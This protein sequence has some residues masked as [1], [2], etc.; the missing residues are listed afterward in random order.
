MTRE[1]RIREAVTVF[2]ATSE[3]GGE[4]AHTRRM[5]A[6]QTLENLGFS[7]D[8]ILSARAHAL[9]GYSVEQ[10]LEVLAGEGS[11]VVVA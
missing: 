1:Q 3:S 7:E 11:E 5:E 6:K 4:L 8:Q 9:D 10:V 2:V